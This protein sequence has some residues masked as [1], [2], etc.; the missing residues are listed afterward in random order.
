MSSLKEQIALVTGSSSGIGAAIARA[1]ADAGAK[2]VINYASSR[3]DAEK[4]KA[5]IK[6]T[7]D[8]E[9]FLDQVDLYKH[10]DREHHNAHY[11]HWFLAE[12]SPDLFKSLHIVLRYSG[13]TRGS[14]TA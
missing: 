10:R 8:E 11:S 3:E 13:L 2:V 14:N 6:A 7:R 4:V 12:D 1:F 5:N 9:I